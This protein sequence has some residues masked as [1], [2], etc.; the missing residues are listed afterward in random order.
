MG[1]ARLRSILEYEPKKPDPIFL[2]QNRVIVAGTDL[3]C[4]PGAIR[5][6]ELG[7]PGRANLDVFAVCIRHVDVISFPL[8]RNRTLRPANHLSTRQ[9][10]SEC[11][12]RPTVCRSVTE[13]VIGPDGRP[14]SFVRNVCEQTPYTYTVTIRRGFESRTLVDGKWQPLA[15]KRD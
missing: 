12:P 2:P 8:D 4:C 13:T 11:A 1:Y 15:S 14:Q 5:A 7:V 10:H 9:V 6:E 3:D